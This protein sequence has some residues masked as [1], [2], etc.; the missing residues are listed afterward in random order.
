[1]PRFIRKFLNIYQGEMTQF[2]Y[3]ALLL[4]LIRFG[5]IILENYAETAFLKRFGIKHLPTLYMINAISTFFITGFVSSLQKRMRDLVLLF[6]LSLFCGLSIAIGRLLSPL[7]FKMIYPVFYLLKSQYE[8]ILGLIFWNIANDIF[9][10]RQSKR[11]FPTITAG[12]T[13]G[14][15]AASFLTPLFSKFFSFDG[16]TWIYLLTMIFVGCLSFYMEK[17]VAIVPFT[18]EHGKEGKKEKTSFLND[19]KEIKLI[20]KVYVVVKILILVTLIPNMVI[21]ILNYTFNFAA[22][23][24]FVTESGILNFFSYFKGIQ[25]ILSLITLLFVGRLYNRFGL[26]IAMMIHPANYLVSFLG[27][28]VSMDAVMASYAR[29]S[30]TIIRNTINNPARSALMGILPR[31]G[32]TLLRAFLRGMVVRIGIMSGS[33]LIYLVNLLFGPKYIPIAGAVLSGVWFV[34]CVFLK[35]RYSQILGQSILEGIIDFRSLEPKDIDTIFKDPAGRDRLLAAFMDSRGEDRVWYGKILKGISDPRLDEAIISAMN[36]ESDQIKAQLLSLMD[37]KK[38]AKYVG[39]FKEMVK[40][41]ADEGFL[42]A[43]VQKAM[44]FEDRAK[45]ELGKALLEELQ[46]PTKK[47]YGIWLL[48][49]TSKFYYKDMIISWLFSME[50]DEIMA[51]LVAVQGARDPEFLPYVK[52]IAFSKDK[53]QFR[54]KAIEALLSYQSEDLNQLLYPYL[55][56]PDEQIRYTCL[57]AILIQDKESMGAVIKMLIDPSPRIRELAF[58]KLKDTDYEDHSMLLEGL[59]LPTRQAKELLFKLLE[60]VEITDTQLFKYATEKIREAYQCLLDREVLKPMAN[61]HIPNL[62]IT[63]LT[64][65]QAA[66]VKDLLRVIATQSKNPEFKAG[67][68]A[69]YSTDSG[70]RGNALELLDSVLDRRIKVFLMPLLEGQEEEELLRIAKRRLNLPPLDGDKGGIIKRLLSRGDWVTLALCLEWIQKYGLWNRL[71]DEVTKLWGSPHVCL[72][73]L[74][75]KAFGRT[76]PNLECSMEEGVSLTEKILRLRSIYLFQD[77]SV[78]ELAAIATASKEVEFPKETIVFK[79]GDKGDSLYLVARGKVAVIKAIGEEGSPEGITLA[80]I[81]PGD[82]FGE[83]ALIEDTVRSATIKTLEPSVFLVLEK[84]EFNELIIEYPT[85]PLNICRVLSSRLRAL[86]KKL[87]GREQDT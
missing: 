56:D 52:E 76:Q 21:P 2:L 40:Q 3:C 43:L 50:P 86:Q 33:G 45:Y 49:P 87:T 60:Q 80:E 72:R 14:S 74:A 20:S 30:T 16:I 24:Q 51:G 27:L 41:G 58:Q 19:L 32:R 77:L 13:L 4:F 82:Y 53:S 69:L 42:R 36:E 62:L 34:S 59:R 73:E 6:Y 70:A 71:Q 15:I 5:D 47:A 67:W 25:N 48:Y 64:E 46:T 83:M 31:R 28:F 17:S 63:H 54:V 61:E 8:V 44:A 35:A 78:Q 7:D 18:E 79:E 57:N 26:P 55:N 22:D 84:H 66:I 38:A 37:E 29:I 39:F 11:L 85:I 75:R 9:N 23:K 1:M 12:G 68:K 10:T 81:G 65:R